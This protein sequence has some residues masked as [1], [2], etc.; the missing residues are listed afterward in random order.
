ME[1]HTPSPMGFL[2]EVLGRPENERAFCVLPVGYPAEGAR[3]PDITRKSVEP[4][5]VRR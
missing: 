3:V 2:R 1:A 4:V 5:L